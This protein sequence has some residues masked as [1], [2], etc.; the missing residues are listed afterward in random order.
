MKNTWNSI[1]DRFNGRENNFDI[2]RLMA[3]TLV[4]FSHA[5]PLTLGSNEYEPLIKLTRG[6]ETFGGLGV[7]IFFILSGFLITYSFE[8]CANIYEYFRN[9]ILR[10]FPALLILIF[11]T[12]F[13]LGPILTTLDLKTYFS[14]PATLRYLES[15]MLVNMQYGL[16]GVFEH[17]PYPNAVNGSLWTL[18]Y[19]FFFYMIVA[20]LGS[21]KMLKKIII[22]P[23]FLVVL[24]FSLYLSPS[25]AVFQ[26]FELFKY[27]CMGIIVYLLRY[28]IKLNKFIA[29]FCFIL[30]VSLTSFG[31]YKVAFIFF[32]TYIIFYV[33][34]GMR[35][36][37]RKLQ[38]TGDFSYGMYIYA[39]PVQQLVTYFFNGHISP[40]NN[41]VVSAVITLIFSILSWFKIERK[42]L[43]FKSSN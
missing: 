33:G 22:I 16:P 14:S 19:E 18:W 38:E 20:V 25:I 26:Y 3:A 6:Q 12:V 17:N 15:F 11:F 37:L 41:F 5:Y 35:K 2:L 21:L 32:G 42:C 28:N 39:F 40:L 9:R 7:S 24:F 34:F 29:F 8:R 23:L 4:I 27:F 43:H 30:L 13:V 10:I 1:A 31:Y 36:I